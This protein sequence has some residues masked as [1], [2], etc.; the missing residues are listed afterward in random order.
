MDRILVSRLQLHR[1]PARVWDQDSGERR[2]VQD[3]GRNARTTGPS[4][5]A[6]VMVTAAVVTPDR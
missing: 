2:G 5:I 4:L 3:R 6:A 1:A